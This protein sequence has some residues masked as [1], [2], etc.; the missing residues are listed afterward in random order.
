VA[1]PSEDCRPDRGRCGLT[2]SHGLPIFLH[3]F[4]STADATYVTPAVGIYDRSCPAVAA[5]R[6]GGGDVRAGA[7]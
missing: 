4:Y 3:I 6:A 2:V 5:T 1:V 7:K